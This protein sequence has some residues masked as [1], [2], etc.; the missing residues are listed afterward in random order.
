MSKPSIFSKDYQKKMKIRRKKIAVLV[1]V[2]LVLALT[3]SLYSKTSF[4]GIISKINLGKNVKHLKINEIKPQ[5]KTNEIATSKQESYEVVLS[6]GSKIK[7]VYDINGNVKKFKCIEP[8]SSETIYSINISGNKMIVFD[9]NKQSILL[10]DINGK[11]SDI[12]RK[13]YV[14]TDGTFSITKDIKLQQEPQYIWC[15]SP[16]FIDEESIVYISQLPWFGRTEK[17]V[18]MYNITKSTY[19]TMKDSNGNDLSGNNIKFNEMSSQ[20]LSITVDNKNYILSS[21]G[22]INQ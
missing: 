22:S 11:I 6:S 5:T 19:L 8:V 16:I 21:S 10:I 7:A 13:D 2:I 18:W 15:S 4:S 3:F 20:G 14:S 12:T 17:Y 1:L 9:S